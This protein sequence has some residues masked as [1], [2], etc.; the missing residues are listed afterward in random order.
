MFPLITFITDT[1]IAYVFQAFGSRPFA[2]HSKTILIFTMAEWD[3]LATALGLQGSESDG[4]SPPSSPGGSQSPE[5]HEGGLVVDADEHVLVD[6]DPYSFIEEVKVENDVPHDDVDLASLALANELANISGE[7][8]DKE[9]IKAAKA[10]ESI[11]NWTVECCPSILHPDTR[12][13]SQPVKDKE[14]PQVMLNLEESMKKGS[15]DMQRGPMSVLWRKALQDSLQLSNEYAI[16]K[17][18]GIA[19][20]KKRRMQWVQ[21]EY[22]LLEEEFVQVTEDISEQ[23]STGDYCS[24]A[25]LVRREGG[26]IAG[27]VAAKNYLTSAIENHKK[28]IF[29]GERPWFIQNK[30]T[31]ML[32]LHHVQVQWKDTHREKGSHVQTYG[33]KQKALPAPAAGSRGS[34]DVAAAEVPARTRV[35][36]KLPPPTPEQSPRA[37]RKLVGDEKMAVDLMKQIKDLKVQV[38]VTTAS[39]SDLISSITMS[40]PGDPWAWASTHEWLK[41]LRDASAKMQRAKQNSFWN[42]VV[43][44]DEVKQY[45][46]NSPVKT[47]IDV[48]TAAKLELSQAEEALQKEIT[49]LEDHRQVK[50]R[51]QLPAGVPGKRLNWTPPAGATKKRSKSKKQI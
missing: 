49:A 9:Q 6:E 13:K 18:N 42:D 41:D 16:A 20:A 5:L 7:D 40:E 45:F 8:G 23:T 11:L 48:G 28:G 17:K 29:V 1:W 50:E 19:A 32:T 36:G 31:K 2:T 46:E 24:F 30:M 51:K 44:R 15:F 10:V 38:G 34:Q 33:A 25:V 47:F 35:N 22:E 3:D 43:V 26:G 14:R 4:F 37:G 39:A 21:E 27:L 12:N